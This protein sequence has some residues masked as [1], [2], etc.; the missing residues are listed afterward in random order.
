MHRLFVIIGLLGL[1]ACGTQKEVIEENGA[2]SQKDYP[3]IENF[4][5]ALRYKSNGRLDDAAKLLQKCLEVRQDDDA[6]Y[7]ALS[8]IE[9][10]RGNE[11]ASAEYIQK[12]AALDPGNTWYTQELAYMFFETKQY[13]KARPKH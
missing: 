8:K 12:A 3:Y 11:S 6:V 2:I 1:F 9:L 10:S 7:Y 13:D 5:K 4:Y